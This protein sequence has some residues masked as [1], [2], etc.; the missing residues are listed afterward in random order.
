M[1]LDIDFLSTRFEELLRQ[2]A[3]A[4]SPFVTEAASHLI[5]AGGK[6][7]RPQLVY[8]ASQ[9]GGEADEERLLKAAL[10]MELTHVASLYHDD[11]MDEADV[12]RAAPSA[13]S[14]WGNSIAILIGDYLFAKASILVADL[15]VDYVRLQAETFT[16]LVQGQIAETRGPAT[17]ED[18]L[19][20]YLQVIADKTGSLIAASALFGAM[21]GGASAEVQQALAAYGEEMGLV[22]QLSD[23]IIDITSDVTGKTPG[24]DLREKVPTLPTLLLAQSTDPADQRLKDL[25]ASDLSDDAALA[26]ALA[27]LRA[28]PVIEQARAE[29][30]RRANAARGHLA[31]LPDGQAK[32][33]LAQICDELVARSS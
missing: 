4:D 24:T 31:P 17:D 14:R 13:N 12:R 3:V 6:R 25:L 30:R 28:H 33:L 21:V 22:F 7:F 1:A 16:R 5:M 8:L 27:E 20:H 9:F 18:R 23:D 2:V 15:G 29:V 10:V 11:V 26:E 19:N 32:D